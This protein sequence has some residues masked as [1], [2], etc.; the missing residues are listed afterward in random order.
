[1][2]FISALQPLFVVFSA[3]YRNRWGFPAAEVRQRWQDAGACLLDTAL[4][5]AMVFVTAADGELRLAR[6]Q[7]FEGAHLWT[8]D[9]PRRPACAHPDGE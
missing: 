4:S 9:V 3:G 1:V 7:R 2:P 8:A 5:G 6:R